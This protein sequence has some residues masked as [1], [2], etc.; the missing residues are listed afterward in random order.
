MADDISPSAVLE[1][2]NDN[3]NDEAA[4]DDTVIPEPYDI[5]SYGADYD[6][7]GIVRRLRRGEI[8]MPPFQREYVWNQTEASRFI[9]SLLLGLPVPGIFLATELI[10]RR[11][12]VIDGQQRLKTLLFF[13]TGFFNPREHEQAHRVF[14]LHGVQPEFE[15]KTYESLDETDRIR[16]DNSIIHSTIVKQESPS[17]DDTSI[18]HIFERLNNG[19]RRLTDQEIRVALYHGSLIEKI[20]QLNKYKHWRDV[21]GAPSNRLKD[22]EFIL[23]FF[24]LLLPWRLYTKPMKEFRNRFAAKYRNEDPELLQ[25]WEKRFQETID[26]AWQAFGKTAFRPSGALNAA[27]FD[28]VMVGLAQ[29]LEK[30]P[31]NTLDRNRMTYQ[32]LLSDPEYTEAISRATSDEQSVERRLRKAREAFAEA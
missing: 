9:E 30:G 29:R 20:K 28:S 26:I 25:N 11:F 19:G 18:F 16:L 3:I 27:V 8:F 31:I 13:Y 1:V 6:V 5:T 17:D 23:R 15:G 22:Q 10:T 7:E 14:Q 4:S 24:A 21:F 12:L 32:Q 2:E